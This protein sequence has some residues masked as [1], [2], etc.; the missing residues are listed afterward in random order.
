VAR[1]YQYIASILATPEARAW[2][3]EVGADAR[4]DTPDVFAAAIREEHAK[5]GRVI[6]E[7]GIKLE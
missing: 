7:A 4:A 3:A 5:W 2:F 6:R 1:L